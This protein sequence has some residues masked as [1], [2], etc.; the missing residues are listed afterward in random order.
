MK[1]YRKPAFSNTSG[2]STRSTTFQASFVSASSITQSLSISPRAVSSSLH[3]DR[4]GEGISP[5]IADFSRQGP[6]DQPIQSQSSRQ[7]TLDQKWLSSTHHRTGTMTAENEACLS[8][9]RSPRSNY[10]QPLHNA[11]TAGLTI[12]PISGTTV[13]FGHQPSHSPSLNRSAGGSQ[14][15]N[16][17]TSREGTHFSQRKENGPT[18]ATVSTHGTKRL[19]RVAQTSG[20]QSLGSNDKRPTPSEDHTLRPARSN[21]GGTTGVLPEKQ[22][23]ADYKTA[24]IGGAVTPR[25]TVLPQHIVP[26]HGFGGAKTPVPQEVVN[27]SD[28]SHALN[29][30]APQAGVKRRL[31]MGRTTT[32]YSNKKFKRPV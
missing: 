24:C 5:Q 17:I 3:M 29:P 18:C 4:S 2:Q 13:K 20:Q 27:V 1:D 10:T 15:D 25:T 8:A 28:G 22:G 30:P 23:S 9:S 21:E 32:G 14:K 26:R 19:V 16:N 6:S 31:G 11:I 7:L 12:L